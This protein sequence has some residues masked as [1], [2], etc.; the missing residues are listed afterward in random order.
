MQTTKDVTTLVSTVCG[1][2]DD[3]GMNLNP[4]KCAVLHV[5]RGKPDE[6]RSIQVGDETIA[7]SFHYAIFTTLSTPFLLFSL[8]SNFDFHH[9]PDSLE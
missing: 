6:G 2:G 1:V 3:I 5:R 9:P 8:S 7:E 4:A